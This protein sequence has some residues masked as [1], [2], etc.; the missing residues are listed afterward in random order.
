MDHIF[1]SILFALETTHESLFVGPACRETRLVAFTP[2]LSNLNNEETTLNAPLA[3]F[4]VPLYELLLLNGWSVRSDGCGGYLARR[5]N[6]I[7][8]LAA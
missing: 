1:A 6:T 3:D 5:N 8:T 2:G 7:S 4:E